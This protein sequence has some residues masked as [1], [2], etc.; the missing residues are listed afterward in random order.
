M[1]S[2]FKMNRWKVVFIIFLSFL[3][4]VI[5]FIINRHYGFFENDLKYIRIGKAI[6]EYLNTIWIFSF[7][8]FLNGFISIDMN[9]DSRRHKNCNYLYL[10]LASL[11]LL[12]FI[13]VPVRNILTSVLFI[14]NFL[15]LL[16]SL[17]ISVSVYNSIVNN[18]ENSNI[19]NL[20]VLILILVFPLGILIYQPDLNK[21]YNRKVEKK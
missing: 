14:I 10:I 5:F 21:L 12:E 19:Q 6:T 2:V 1:E 4:S 3:F 18:T 13:V 16:Y 20:K 7:N 8:F 17:Y 11:M 9:I 15:T